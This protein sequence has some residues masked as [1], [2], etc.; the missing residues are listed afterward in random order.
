MHQPENVTSIHSSVFCLEGQ[1]NIIHSF[2]HI[3]DEIPKSFSTP[4]LFAI[5]NA[6]PPYYTLSNVIKS[7]YTIFN[8]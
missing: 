1:S 4:P 6:H 5:C 7:L 8:S 2:Y 3:T